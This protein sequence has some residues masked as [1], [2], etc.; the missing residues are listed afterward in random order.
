MEELV[1][2]DIRRQLTQPPAPAGFSEAELDGLPPA[3]RRHLQAAIAPGTPL[4]TSARLEMRGQLKLGRWLPFW[5]EQILAPHQGF[6]WA[7]R[8][9]G[10][11]GGFDQYLD[12]RGELRWKLLGLVPVMRAD[13]PDVARSAVGRAAGEAMW[14]PTALLP[15][16]GVQWEAADDRHITARFSLDG[17][18]VD[19]QYLLAE[20]G[21]IRSVVFDRWGDPDRSGAW[22]WYPF[23]GEVTGYRSFGGVKVPS[24]GRIGWFYGTNR[25]SEGEFFRFQLTDLEL[26]TSTPWTP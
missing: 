19:L 15:R 23:G 1:A 9:A 12:G 16:F 26:I 2:A 25:W 5:A 24:A 21:R 18:E 3:V 14:L 13:G 7:A 22:G 4:A 17:S 20:D 8:V 6:H 11:I 10:V